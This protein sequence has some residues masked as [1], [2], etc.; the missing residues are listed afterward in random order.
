MLGDMTDELEG[1]AI[2]HFVSTGPESYSFFYGNNEEMSGI[3]GFTLN[4]ENRCYL[5]NDSLT[6]VVKKQLRE[7]TII[8]KSKI[9]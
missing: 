3:K 6:K 2:T 8:N 4:Y 5:N 9:R 7:I 1:K